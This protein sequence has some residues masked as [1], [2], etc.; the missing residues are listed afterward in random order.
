MNT[1]ACL[2]WGSLVWN[3]G[4]LQIHRKWFEDG[5]LL[6]L[7]FARQSNNGRI[8]LVLKSK[9]DLVRSLWSV[10]DTTDVDAAKE[11]LRLREGKINSS[12]VGC[13]NLGNN[14]PSPMGK[15]GEWAKARGITTVIWTALPEKFGGK[16]RSPS[17]EEVL[18]YLKSL[19]GG[20]KDLAE[21]YIRRAPRQIDTKYRRSIEAELGWTPVDN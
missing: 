14:V 4:E 5:P 2:G 16:L 7:E 9:S 1:I 6:P 19:R 12:D 3:P 11:A 13:W 8:T 18:N 20:V 21:E 17:E 15:L 10:F